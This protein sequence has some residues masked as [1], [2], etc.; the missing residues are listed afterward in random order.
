VS[1]PG[2][3]FSFWGFWW[4]WGLGSLG[5][6]F[7]WVF[8]FCELALAASVYTPGVLRGALRFLIN[9]LTYK[10]K[11]PITEPPKGQNNKARKVNGL[12][13]GQAGR[14]YAHLLK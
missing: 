1:Y 10:K 3:R 13:T 4:A 14:A 9:L 11:N 2:S 7:F 12:A 6:F 5:V 8:F